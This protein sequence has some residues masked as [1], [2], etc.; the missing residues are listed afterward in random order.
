LKEYIEHEEEE[1]MRS[2]NG[3]QTVEPLYH[4]MGEELPI[5][6]VGIDIGVIS[7]NKQVVSDRSH[8]AGRQRRS[9]EGADRMDRSKRSVGRRI[10]RLDR[11]SKLKASIANDPIQLH[12]A[13]SAWCAYDGLELFN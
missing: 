1:H 3:E 11:R 12:R 6:S 4:S 2:E 8:G 13:D 9:E 10:D 7:N 5:F